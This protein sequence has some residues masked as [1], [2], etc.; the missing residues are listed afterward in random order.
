VKGDPR[1]LPG[2]PAPGP[3]T[4][5]RVLLAALCGL[6]AACNGGGGRLFGPTLTMAPCR[7]STPRTFAP[8]D[9][10]FDRVSWTRQGALATMQMRRGWRDPTAS[11]LVVLQ[12]SDVAAVKALWEASPDTPFAFDGLAR[13]ALVLN[14]RCP[15]AV[16]P[17]EARSGT[18]ELVGFDLAVGGFITG[19]AR[20]DLV[21]TRAAADA[22]PAGPDMVL[23][24]HVDL[25]Q[26]DPATG[27]GRN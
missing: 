19:T 12:F 1:C 5:L 20:F 10:T 11:D 4:A 18:M 13:V 3:R 26:K 23:D 17:L 9:F 25:T 8:V 27:D 16:Q 22:P 21:D 24:F 14:Q 6:A 15:D 7:D 2:L